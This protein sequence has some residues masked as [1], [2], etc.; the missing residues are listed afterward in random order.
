MEPPKVL[1]Q[2][3]P[4]SHFWVIS[5]YRFCKVGCVLQTVIVSSLVRIK[6]RC[7]DH[8]Q[9]AVHFKYGAYNP[10]WQKQFERGDY[11]VIWYAFVLRIWHFRNNNFSYF[12]FETLIKLFDVLRIWQIRTIQMLR[13]I[14]SFP[15]EFN[16][17]GS[18][19]NYKLKILAWTF[20]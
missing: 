15:V 9:N 2:N 16:I 4:Y 14:F 10:I 13:R 5:S 12:L 19:K 8:R 18:W 20:R 3:C 11:H 1:V 6:V 17:S 7:N